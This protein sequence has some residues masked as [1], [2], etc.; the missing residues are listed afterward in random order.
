MITSYFFPSLITLAVQVP[1][2]GF[3]F[4][5]CKIA[6]LDKNQR[7][8]A[9]WKPV[10]FWAWRGLL[11]ACSDLEKFVS[12]G[13]AFTAP[14]SPCCLNVTVSHVFIVFLGSKDLH[15]FGSWTK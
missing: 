3:S 9:S 10:G 4:L 13:E 5:M 6:G 1:S 7:G 8:A 12:T 14:A 2:W 11:F 15:V